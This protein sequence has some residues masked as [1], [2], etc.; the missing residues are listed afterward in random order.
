MTGAR[1]GWSGRLLRAI[2]LGAATACAAGAAAL[3]P[4]S[5]AGSIT[6]TATQQG[7][8]IVVSWTPVPESEWP[9]SNAG[10]PWTMQQYWVSAWDVNQPRPRLYYYCDGSVRTEGSTGL[11]VTEGNSCTLRNL[12]LGRTYNVFVGSRVSNP[13]GHT[14][15]AGSGDLSAQGG[16]TLCC[17]V[18]SSPRD[19]QLVDRGS[20]TLAA[21]WSAPADTGGSLAVEYA[22]TLDPG[23]LE[24]RSRTTECAFTGLQGGLR[25]STSVRAINQAGTSE[26]GISAAVTLRA[27]PVSAPRSV[28]AAVAGNGLRV[29]WVPPRLSRGQAVARFVARATPSGR[30]CATTTRTCAIT[31]LDE[32]RTYTVVVTAHESDGR[33]ATSRASRPVTIPLAKPARPAEAEPPAPAETPKPSAPLS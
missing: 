20:G 30:S 12:P 17:T 27:P 13:G 14:N 8:D 24:C 16:I 29:T 10:G 32:G 6:V 33:R 15:S 19:V 28:K 23:G 11:P 2:A 7:N 18:P 9:P 5:A 22:V 26:P 4:A 25:Y 1:A 3:A 21:V 31:G